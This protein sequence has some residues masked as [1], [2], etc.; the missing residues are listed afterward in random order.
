[1]GLLLMNMA[2]IPMF[3][4]KVQDVAIEMLKVIVELGIIGFQFLAMFWIYNGTALNYIRQLI[5]QLCL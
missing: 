5:Q 2:Q 1:M 3:L 4:M